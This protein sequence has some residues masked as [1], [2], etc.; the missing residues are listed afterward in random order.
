MLQRLGQVSAKRPW[1]SL[2]VLL[3]FV[4]LAGVIGGPVA[5]RLDGGDGFT[6]ADAE[7]SEATAQ[8]ERATGEETSPGVILLVRGD[9][10][11][12]QAA[13][14]ELAAVPGVARAEPGPA[15]DDGAVV[16]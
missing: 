10:A 9:D 8:L 13:A 11:A 4:V 12:A 15:S 6:P 14:T 16:S 5:G 3:V 7:S 2:L 1:R